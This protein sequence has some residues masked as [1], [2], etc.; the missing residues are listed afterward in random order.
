METGALP[1]LFL[2]QGF[3]ISDWEGID[4]LCEPL[5]AD[6]RFCILTAINAGIDMVREVVID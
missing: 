3:V 1:S 4:E 5:G 6:Y 2:L